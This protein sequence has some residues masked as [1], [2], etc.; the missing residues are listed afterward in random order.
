[1]I[2]ETIAAVDIQIVNAR[3]RWLHGVWAKTSTK[4]NGPWLRLMCFWSGAT[5][6]CKP[7]QPLHEVLAAMTI[8]GVV[9]VD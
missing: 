1:M 6:S 9:P 5:S 4:R 3:W 2:I 8:C 7:P